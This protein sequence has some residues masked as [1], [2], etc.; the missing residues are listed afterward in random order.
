MKFEYGSCS[1]IRF[2]EPSMIRMYNSEGD[3]IEVPRCEKCG[4]AKTCAIGR[5]AYQYICMF[6]PSDDIIEKKDE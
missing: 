4:I 3:E 5:D 6:C 2:V 1:N